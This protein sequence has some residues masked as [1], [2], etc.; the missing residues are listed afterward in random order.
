[1]TTLEYV[2]S[3]KGAMI[4]ADVILPG[5]FNPM[6]VPRWQAIVQDVSHKRGVAV[7]ELMGRSQ[8]FAVSHARFECWSLIR[9]KLGVS[10]PT[11][12]RWWG[13]DHSSVMH[14]VRRWE[15]QLKQVYS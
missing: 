8:R 5:R 14:G 12:A 15:T 9:E 11:I 4:N 10:Y 13:V 7:A 2:E 1:M 6:A 3:L